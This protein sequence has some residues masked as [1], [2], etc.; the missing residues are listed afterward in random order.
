MGGD[1]RRS[2]SHACLAALALLAPVICVSCSDSRKEATE[3][4]TDPS[5]GRVTDIALPLS[6]TVSNI[7]IPTELPDPSPWGPNP[8]GSYAAVDVE[9]R[10]TSSAPVP[11]TAL[12]VRVTAISG[13]GLSWQTRDVEFVTAKEIAGGA[14]LAAHLYI[15]V[16]A[17]ES[18]KAFVF[19]PHG[20]NA[21][22]DLD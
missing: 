21:T 13:K 22:I 3:V 11:F 20:V 17:G 5:S 2:S 8:G 6:I 19:D 7:Q 1:R 10:N 9:I 16:P 4:T 15:E 12:D 18:P 14:L